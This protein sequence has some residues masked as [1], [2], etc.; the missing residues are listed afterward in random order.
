M[1]PGDASARW[2]IGGMPDGGASA[3]RLAHDAL[4]VLLLRLLFGGRDVGERL[5]LELLV[6]EPDRLRLE[7]EL[8]GRPPRRGEAAGDRRSRAEA[9]ARQASQSAGQGAPEGRLF[10]LL[11][12]V[13]GRSGASRI[14]AWNFAC[15]A[16]SRAVSWRP[17][18][19]SVRPGFPL[20]PA[21]S[22]KVNVTIAF[23]GLSTGPS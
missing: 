13:R 11:L 9:L 7:A 15:S 12:E 23:V 3:D 20:R 1:P 14:P 19:V 17:R 22:L 6:D 5:E 18:S 2:T 8:E 10:R 21:P 4:L 16:A